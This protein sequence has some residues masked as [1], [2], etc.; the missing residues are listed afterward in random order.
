VD[1][2]LKHLHFDIHWEFDRDQMEKYE[3]ALAA[4]KKVF[5]GTGLLAS[6]EKLFIVKED[7]ARVWTDAA[8]KKDVTR[9]LAAAY[10]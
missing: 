9:I 1:Y 7:E 5:T 8:A 10:N 2:A 6:D 3:A 4:N